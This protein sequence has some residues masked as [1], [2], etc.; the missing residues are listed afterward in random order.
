MST[1]SLLGGIR[2][3]RAGKSKSKKG[4]MS[5]DNIKNIKIPQVYG[6]QNNDPPFNNDESNNNDYDERPSEENLE[7]DYVEEQQPDEDESDESDEADPEVDE[8]D[9]AKPEVDEAKPKVDEAEPDK[10]EPKVD[11]AKPVV[12]EK[13]TKKQVLVPQLFG[14]RDQMKMYHWQTQSYSRHVASGDFV[15]SLS[16]FID[17]FV[18]IYQGKYGRIQLDNIV[19]IKLKNLNDT[20]VIEYLNKYKKYLLYTLP[21]TLNEVTDTDLLNL[22]DEMLAEANKLLYLFTL[23]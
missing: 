19:S 6:G 8:P 20:T 23:R 3:R 11:E 7:E 22:K 18:E 10:A 2:R 21:G 5:Y 16:G 15:T 13:E 4:D 17:T 9:E 1:S 14:F 12:D